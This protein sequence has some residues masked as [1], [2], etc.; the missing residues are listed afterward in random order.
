MLGKLAGS[1]MY[2]VTKAFVRKQIEDNI[3][4]SLDKKFDSNEKPV[5]KQPIG[6]GSKKK[7]RA[8]KNTVSYLRDTV[9]DQPIVQ[10]PVVNTVLKKELKGFYKYL[11]ALFFL[12]LVYALFLRDILVLV[13]SVYDKTLVIPEINSVAVDTLLFLVGVPFGLIL[14]KPKKNEDKNG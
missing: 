12:W 11:G 10:E 6:K 4:K 3:V 5:D 2:K 1:I 7:N 13:L 9:V 14:V 8:L